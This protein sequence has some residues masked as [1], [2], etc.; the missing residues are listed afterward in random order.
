ML[1]ARIRRQTQQQREGGG[2]FQLVSVRGLRG[3][4]VVE[5]CGG[6]GEEVMA[7]ILELVVD[8]VWEEVEDRGGREHC[9]EVAS[10]LLEV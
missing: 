4:Y 1:Q 3:E 9:L 10:P 2:Q 6:L 8:A 5:R 7:E